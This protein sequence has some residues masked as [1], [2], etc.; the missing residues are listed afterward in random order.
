MEAIY[1]TAMFAIDVAVNRETEYVNLA[2]IVN[3]KSEVL[4]TSKEKD[5]KTLFNIKKADRR[6][7]TLKYSLLSER[8]D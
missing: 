6:S 8:K 4:S 7:T 2:W 3:F 1:F 5:L